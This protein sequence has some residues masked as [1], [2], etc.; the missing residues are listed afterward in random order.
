MVVK[1]APAKSPQIRLS[2]A[3]ELQPSVLA[4]SAHGSKGPF[5]FA[6]ATMSYPGSMQ[7]Q[8]LIWL[9]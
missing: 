1:V 9:V 4:V 7:E 6:N 8:D 3:V 2:I 5:F